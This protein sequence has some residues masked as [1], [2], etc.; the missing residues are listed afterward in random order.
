MGNIE[1]IL[2]EIERRFSSPWGYYNSQIQEGILKTGNFV[3]RGDG[4]MID[5]KAWQRFKEKWL[6]KDN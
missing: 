4:I 2:T 1:K 6:A 3:K 5:P